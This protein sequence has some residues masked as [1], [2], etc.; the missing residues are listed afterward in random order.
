[1]PSLTEN[2]IIALTVVSALLLVYF[3]VYFVEKIKYARFFK[4]E[5]FSN[6]KKDIS[7]DVLTLT[8]LTY[9][10]DSSIAMP[11]FKQEY[12]ISNV[13][14]SVVQKTSSNP[15]Y[16]LY[17]Y[18]MNKEFSS[19][20]ECV[21]HLDNYIERYQNA[22][23]LKVSVKEQESEL[24]NTIASRT[25]GYKLEY[26]CKELNIPTENGQVAFA[27]T[28]RPVYVQ[29]IY[30]SPKRGNQTVEILR[31]DCN[32]AENLRDYIAKKDNRVQNDER[33]KLTP[34]LRAKIFERDKFACVYC[35]ASIANGM[36]DELHCDH[37]YPISRG[38]K[39][40][41]SN[42]QTLCKS[43]NLNKSDKWREEDQD[44]YKSRNGGRLPY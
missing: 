10:Y 34:A 22:L 40:V 35:G 42:L 12:I 1:M 7:P 41:E 31:L 18:F 32:Q 11:D 21:K 16:Y 6:L 28:P 15:N 43:C 27:K 44:A 3:V 24:N 39:T 37:I 5:E 14:R 2:L 4:S 9:N 8:S 20:E 38:G 23:K 17:K 25:Q 26:C 13:S 30:T 29:F 36:T 33:S 19:N